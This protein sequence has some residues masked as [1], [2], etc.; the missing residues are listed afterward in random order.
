MCSALEEADKELLEN[1][2]VERS[3]IEEEINEL[4]ARNVSIYRQ[5]TY[6]TWIFI[7]LLLLGLFHLAF[8]MFLL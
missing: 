2:R 1:N 8:N 6:D 7:Q 4:R 3:H 5:C